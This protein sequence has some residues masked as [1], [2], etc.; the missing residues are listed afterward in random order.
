MIG[1]M[2]SFDKPLLPGGPG[3]KGSMLHPERLCHTLKGRSSLRMG[4]IPHGERQRVV[5]H[6]EKKGGHRSPARWRTPAT[7]ADWESAWLSED[8]KRVPS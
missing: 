4:T 3:S 5:G 7:V 6:D 2:T 8:F 1:T